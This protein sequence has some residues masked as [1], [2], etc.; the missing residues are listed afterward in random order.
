[1]RTVSNK[2]WKW[3]HPGSSEGGGA[4][5]EEEGEMARRGAGGVGWVAAHARRRR[6]CVN[7]SCS[8]QCWWGRV[9]SVPQFLQHMFPSPPPSHSVVSRTVTLP[10]PT[11]QP[12]SH[13]HTHIPHTL[14]TYPPTHPP[15]PTQTLPTHP[16]PPQDYELP[17]ADAPTEDKVLAARAEAYERFDQDR[18]GR[19]GRRGR[20]G[21]GEWGHGG[22]RRVCVCL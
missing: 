12:H 2:T 10:Q 17:L 14:Y 15:N 8:N 3:R 1:M 22:R 6:G 21:E 13:T 16:P 4:R 5:R 19:G 11:T 18:W 7:A 20:M 9:P